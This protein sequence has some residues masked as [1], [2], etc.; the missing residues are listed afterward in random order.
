M[1]LKISV[2]ICESKISPDVLHQMITAASEDCFNTLR[3]MNAAVK[4][5]LERLSIALHLVSPKITHTLP[6]N[7]K[8]VVREDNTL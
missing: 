5:H 2:L 6:P 7:P 3:I 8:K 1:F 4:D